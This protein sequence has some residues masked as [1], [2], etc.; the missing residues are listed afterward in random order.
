[1]AVAAAIGVGNDEDSISNRLANA[2]NRLS[3]KR[4]LMTPSRSQSGPT[5]INNPAAPSIGGMS[6]INRS[7]EKMTLAAPPSTTTSTGG[8][9]KVKGSSKATT[10]TNRRDSDWNSSSV[11]NDDQGYGSMRS[12]A[13]DAQQNNPSNSR[14]CSDLSTASQVSFLTGIFGG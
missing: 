3:G 1:M 14:R 11:S 7:I 4:P 13:S 5:S 6:E 9:T 8:V 12:S 10:T 2:T